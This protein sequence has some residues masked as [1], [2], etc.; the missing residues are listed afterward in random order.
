MILNE[1]INEVRDQHGLE[2]VIWQ[3][4]LVVINTYIVKCIFLST[5]YI[6]MLL[7]LISE[8]HQ[9]IYFVQKQQLQDRLQDRLHKVLMVRVDVS[10]F[11][12]NFLLV[13][14]QNFYT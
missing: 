7:Y 14:T 5:L 2:P 8:Y 12:R 1:F 13:I 6:C 11:E 3:W 4:K 9:F 10:L